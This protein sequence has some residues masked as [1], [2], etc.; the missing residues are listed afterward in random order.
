MTPFELEQFAL[1][2][3]TH[4][5]KNLDH[6]VKSPEPFDMKGFYP[7]EDRKPELSVP[8]LQNEVLTFTQEYLMKARATG[9][10]GKKQFD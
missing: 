8:A 4:L 3:N 1:A 2:L 10:L 6:F 9:F 5:S 7:D